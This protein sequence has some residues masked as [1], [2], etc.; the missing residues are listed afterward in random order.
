METM[1]C[2]SIS[3]GS[4]TM[5]PILWDSREANDTVGDF[6]VKAADM[7]I[8]PKLGR[9]PI[10]AGRAVPI[11]MGYGNMRRRTTPNSLISSRI[12]P[13]NWLGSGMS[14][15]VRAGEFVVA[16]AHGVAGFGD[17]ADNFI[18]LRGNAAVGGD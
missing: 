3:R 4:R 13:L 7:A 18:K 1:L 17:G 16:P 8:E 6:S 5:P 11:P 14:L 2:S 15:V 9:V 12:S 10:R